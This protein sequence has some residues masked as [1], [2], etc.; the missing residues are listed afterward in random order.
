MIVAALLML[1][2]ALFEIVEIADRLPDINFEKLN[3]ATGAVWGALI[4]LSYALLRVGR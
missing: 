4:V 2:L 3:R 1:S